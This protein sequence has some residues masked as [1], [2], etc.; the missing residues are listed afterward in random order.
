MYRHIVA[1]DAEIEIGEFVFFAEEITSDVSF[2]YR[3]ENE[4]PIKNGTMHITRG[5]YVRRKYSFKT[6]ITIN[7]E[8]PHEH[9]H[10]FKELMS[11]PQTI[12]CPDMGGIFK[13]NVIFSRERRGGSPD[14]VPY[15]VKV[16]EIPKILE[17]EIPGEYREWTELKD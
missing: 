4:Q 13:A 8:R 16:N 5:K 2:N 12:I 6:T 14:K 15:T 3:E 11:K 17:S 7:P 9:D 1:T 10:I